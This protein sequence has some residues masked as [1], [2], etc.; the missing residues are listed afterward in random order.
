MSLSLRLFC[1]AI[2]I[3]GF[4]FPA[5]AESIDEYVNSYCEVVRKPGKKA[6]V[7]LAAKIIKLAEKR[8]AHLKPGVIDRYPELVYLALLK[9]LIGPLDNLDKLGADKR[10]KLCRALRT[11]RL[12]MIALS[13]E[14][15]RMESFCESASQPASQPDAKL[16]GEITGLAKQNKINLKP[17]IANRYPALVYQQLSAESSKYLGDTQD[18]LDKLE[19]IGVEKR[20]KLCRILENERLQLKR[21][22]INY[23]FQSAIVDVTESE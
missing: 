17:D 2:L 19:E 8:Q 5:H 16:L 9:G 20:A 13:A 1:C 12:G 6:D 10:I 11:E 15:A 22:D 3:C 7:E 4:V 23:L 14:E 21:L 18:V